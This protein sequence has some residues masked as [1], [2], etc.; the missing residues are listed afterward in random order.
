MT[1]FNPND[2]AAATAVANGLLSATATTRN[3]TATCSALSPRSAR[4]LA[5]ACL[6][7]M[8]QGDT[9]D[10]V[11]MLADLHRITEHVQQANADEVA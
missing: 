9:H 3:V 4:S 7:H 5:L 10:G 2:I 11:A 6:M 1:Q 8:R